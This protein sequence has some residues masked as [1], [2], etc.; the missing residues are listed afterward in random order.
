MFRPVLLV[1]T[2]QLTRGMNHQSRIAEIVLWPSGDLGPRS[3]RLHRE[4]VSRL[5]VSLDH[6]AASLWGLLDYCLSASTIRGDRSFFSEKLTWAGIVL[7]SNGRSVLLARKIRGSARHHISTYKSGDYPQIPK[8]NISADGYRNTLRD[9]F[10]SPGDTRLGAVTIRDLTLFSFVPRSSLVTPSVLMMSPHKPQSVFKASLFLQSVIDSE[11][12][13]R[14]FMRKSRYRAFA[15]EKSIA[16][17]R[18]HVTSR[19]DYLYKIAKSNLNQKHEELLNLPLPYAWREARQALRQLLVAH[20][21]RGINLSDYHR[22]VLVGRLHELLK[23]CQ[24][25]QSAWIDVS[26][27]RMEREDAGVASIRSMRNP[28]FSDRL[29]Q[30][31]EDLAVVADASWITGLHVGFNQI[32]VGELKAPILLGDF[33]SRLD[34]TFGKLALL[35]AIHIASNEEIEKPLIPLLFL[36]H[37]SVAVGEIEE[38]VRLTDSAKKC[39]RKID[40]ILE[41]TCNSGIQ[42]IV[43]DHFFEGH[44]AEPLQDIF[45]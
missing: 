14:R 9:L 37:P 15:E 11:R 44:H 33:C 25:A 40:S 19:L 3:L 43:V 16:Q 22:G 7:K 21:E 42:V 34:A 2:K 28:A 27:R 12:A 32:Y 1:N 45:G 38:G 24:E 4:R 10:P 29:P 23:I 8:A 41:F 17:L 5:A 31:L 35:C 39:L 6:G 13:E 36:E 30:A 26:E 20:E 18:A